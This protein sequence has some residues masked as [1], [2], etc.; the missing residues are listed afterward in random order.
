[1]FLPKSW[2]ANLG[3]HPLEGPESTLSKYFAAYAKGYIEE[4][5]LRPLITEPLIFFEFYPR[6]WPYLPLLSCL[7]STYLIMY[8]IN[9]YGSNSGQ[10]VKE[11][12]LEVKIDYMR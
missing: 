6:L 7:T 9:A 3:G 2:E 4:L 11:N 1:M 8:E 12:T 5:G 10:L